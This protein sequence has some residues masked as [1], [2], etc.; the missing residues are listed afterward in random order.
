MADN[1]FDKSKRSEELPEDFRPIIPEPEIHRRAI[2]GFHKNYPVQ[3]NP[4]STHT[5]SF[6]QEEIKR[7]MRQGILYAVALLVTFIMTFIIT[8]ACIKISK[9]PIPPT[10]A[11][12]T[13]ASTAQATELQSE[14]GSSEISEEYSVQ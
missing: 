9:E 14:E 10:T 7:K 13:Q 11:V 5:E 3:E 12:A 2:I 1:E 8:D 4:T 6:A